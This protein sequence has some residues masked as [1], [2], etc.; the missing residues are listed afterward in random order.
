MTVGSFPT[1]WK[2][3][4]PITTGSPSIG[5][6]IFAGLDVGAPFP[7]FAFFAF[8]GLARGGIPAA[9]QFLLRQN[10]SEDRSRFISCL[11]CLTASQRS[12]T[13]RKFLTS[14]GGFILSSG[15]ASRKTKGTPVSFSIGLYSTEI[16]RPGLD[17]SFAPSS[18]LVRIPWKSGK[19]L[20]SL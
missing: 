11:I 7:L 17:R 14:D 2:G 1:F 6:D 15:N 13:V 3:C 4:K 5:T 19:V 9:Y 16:F 10:H 8:Q 20:M 18:N 12:E